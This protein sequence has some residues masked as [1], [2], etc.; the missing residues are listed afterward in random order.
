MQRMETQRVIEHLIGWEIRD[1]RNILAANERLAVDESARF[2]TANL[3]AAQGLL[4]ASMRPCVRHFRW[5]R[6]AGRWSSECTGATLRIIADARGGEDVYGVE[7]F[8]GLPEDWRLGFPAGTFG[9]DT[10]PAR[11][12]RSLQLC[13][14][15]VDLVGPRLQ[16]GS[17]IQFDEY[18]NFTGW[19]NHEFKAGEEYVRRS[20]GQ[21]WGLM[22][23][24][25][26]TGSTTGP[27]DHSWQ[28]RTAVLRRRRSP[29]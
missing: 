8:T 3:A 12:R 24:D 17:I 25:G 5:H 26:I 23:A 7:T 20:V 19:R 15:R 18:F 16:V 27:I 2:A 13:R 22:P 28:R 6:A 4:S 29:S 9:A 11:R 14:S 1:R 10:L 21:T